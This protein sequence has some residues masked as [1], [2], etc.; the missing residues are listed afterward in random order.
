MLVGVL[1]AQMMA[2]AAKADPATSAV[3]I[4]SYHTSVTGELGGSIRVPATSSGSSTYCNLRRGNFTR[5]V[6]IL[7]QTLREIY[8]QPI[9]VDQDFGPATEQAL[10]NVQRRFKIT[11]DGVY[12]PQTRD[13]LCWQTT[14]NEGCSWY[15]AGKD[16]PG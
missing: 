15:P 10:K 16:G 11:A 3:A 4:C 7:Q 13:H 9:A 8:D 14:P 5:G 2:A 1:A 6:A 12:G